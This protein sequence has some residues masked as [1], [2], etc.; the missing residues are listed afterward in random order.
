MDTISKLISVIPSKFYPRIL[1]LIFFAI[2]GMFLELAGIGMIFPVI[3]VL[4]D[5]ES[6]IFTKIDFYIGYFFPN[7]ELDKRFLILF[8]LLGIFVL[9]N[10]FLF[11]LKWFAVSFNVKFI[12]EISTDLMNRYLNIEYVFFTKKNSSEILRN[13]INECSVLNKKIL[14]PLLFI[15]MDI[16][17]LF[18][19]AA[20]LLLV[21]FKITLIIILFSITLVLL[22]YFLSKKYLYKLGLER[23][24]FS[25][26][27]LKITQ[28]TFHGLKII[29]VLKKENY[30]KNLFSKNMEKNLNVEKKGGLIIFAPK[31]FTEVIFVSIFIFIVIYLLKINTNFT[32]ILPQLSI[33]FIAAVRLIPCINRLSLNVQTIKYGKSS[34]DLLYNEFNL[35]NNDNKITTNENKELTKFENIE[36]KDI[37]F[38]YNQGKIVLNQINLKIK[39]G[40]IIGIIGKTGEGKS[41]L[42]NII[43]GLLKPNS[44]SIFL[45]DKLLKTNL[46]K[47]KNFIGYIPQETFLIEG[48]ILQNIIFTLEKNFEYDKKRLENAIKWSKVDNFLNKLQDDIDLLV[49]ERGSNLS[50][51]QQQRI[52]IARALYRDPKIL[53]LDESTNSLDEETESE[54]MDDICQLK[55]EKSII[56]ISHRKSSLKN[57]DH[58]YEIKD[59]KLIKVK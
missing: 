16:L 55:K 18:G 57:C 34:I 6:E 3:E 39:K 42:I 30:F 45:D 44:G 4:L 13:V 10:I 21:E 35:L 47:F 9:K 7:F 43:I 52:S 1:L 31:L 53:I 33:Y 28:E 38:N 8:F 32:D 20:L 36:L 26:M 50:G 56:I 54:I 49:R 37:N 12:K 59:R 58:I 15:L 22:Y 24:L 14:I 25:R 27:V 5:R 40:S 48:T 51:G 17:I 23:Q 29:K 2:A 11:F 46:Y 41:T 19:I